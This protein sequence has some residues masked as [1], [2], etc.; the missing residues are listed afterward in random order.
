MHRSRLRPWIT[1]ALLALGTSAC[2]RDAKM[3]AEREA[4]ARKAA[5]DGKAGAAC[6]AAHAK[7]LEQ[8]LLAQCALSDRV[9][10]TEVPAAPWKP[11][12]S[13]APE[14]VLRL[15][16]GPAGVVLGWGPPMPVAEL[17]SRLA[18]EREQAAVMAEAKGRPRRDGWV[19]LI[20]SATPRAD[21]AAVLK[22]LAE[23]E[24]RQ[25][26][27]QLATDATGPLPVPRDAKLLADVKARVSAEDPSQ[28]AMLL[29]QEIEQTMP[30][31]PAL[32]QTFSNVATVDA[33]QRCPLLA[34]G[35]SEGLV[36]CGCAKEDTM[37]TLFYAVSMGLEPPTR[38]AAAV[39]VT[40]DPAAAPRPG[41]TWAA[42]VAGLDEAALAGLW[43]SP[44]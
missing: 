43:V 38:L 25:G 19:L 23:A 14:D 37:M 9:L 13:A 6:D 33:E 11:S 17:P 44:S 30:P 24:L 8:E 41:A 28:R 3:P 34:R 21:V 15:E 18:Q 31:C 32:V 26:H 2:D 7:A 5:V 29:A 10:M 35:I 16:L 40:L 22:G 36:S 4:D 27:L 42:V 39:A 12:P 1:L 20:A